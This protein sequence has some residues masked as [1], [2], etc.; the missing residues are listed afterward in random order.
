MSERNTQTDAVP[1]C[2][3]PVAAQTLCRTHLRLSLPLLLYLLLLLLKPETK[4]KVEL[5]VTILLYLLSAS[6][7]CLYDLTISF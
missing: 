3:A 4:K 1:C 2:S 7:F 5:F 6:P